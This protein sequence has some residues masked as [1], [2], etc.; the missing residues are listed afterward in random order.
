M[1]ARGTN[2]KSISFTLGRTAY[3]FILIVR[4]KVGSVLGD[5]M[6]LHTTPVAIKEYVVHLF[7]VLSL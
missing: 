4:W 2:S 7:M 5:P 1:F 3:N 6:F